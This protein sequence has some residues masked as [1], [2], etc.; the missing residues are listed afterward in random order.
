MAY[1]AVYEIAD[2]DDIVVDILGKFLAAFGD[3]AA[4][5]A[6]LIVLSI[7]V[8]VALHLLGG[9]GGMVGMF[10]KLGK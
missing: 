7:V 8:A 9:V 5:I 3:Q 2:I 4:I 1:T 10:R 6:A